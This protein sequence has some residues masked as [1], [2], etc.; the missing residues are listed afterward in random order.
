MDRDSIVGIISTNYA[1][2]KLGEL[3][4]DRTIASLPYGG[5]YRLIDFPLSNMINAGITTVGVITPFKYRSLIDHIGSGKA[6]SLDR[7]N[8]GLQVLPGSVFGVSNMNSRFML[9]DLDRNK[10]FL[11]RSPAPYVLITA[12]NIVSKLDYVKMFDEHLKSGADITMAYCAATE[13]DPDLNSINLVNG[14]VMSVSRSTKVGQPAFQDCF[15]I[16][17]DLLLNI[18]DWYSAINYMDLFEILQG[19]YDKMD[20]RG[21]EYCG[22]TGSIFT[23]EAYFRKSMD[24]MRS[25]VREALFS[26][27]APVLTKLH[28]T[29]PTK[30]FADAEVSGSLIPS[31]CMIYGAV[32]DCILFRNVTIAPGAR[33]VNSIIMQGCRIEEG[34]VIENAIIEK[35]TVISADTVLKS[36]AKAPIIIAKE[37]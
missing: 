23:T 34:A 37:D 4:S 21:Y 2:E 22:Y 9:R 5:R 27:D 28:D 31:G 25:D 14:R 17:R 8:G 3:T 10:V 16:S 30:Y 11:T 33:V 1:S 7:K 18:M 15:I 35:N 36:S 13:D 29:M 26:A 24:L 19:D 20:V 6:W 32:K 12:T